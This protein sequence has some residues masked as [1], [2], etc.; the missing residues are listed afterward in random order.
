MNA[1]R[2]VGMIALLAVA[3]SPV[4]GRA[5]DPPPTRTIE[6]RTA[7][8]VAYAV[9]AQAGDTIAWKA[10]GGRH[11]VV[12]YAGPA[13]YTAFDSG[14]PNNAQ[15][16]GNPAGMT[17]YN[18]FTITYGGGV[19]KYRCTLA[20]S[21]GKAYSTVDG[22]GQCAGMCGTITDNPPADLP[23][24]PAISSPSA[25]SPE[26][27]N[28][29]FIIG[30]APPGASAVKVRELFRG[31]A[32]QELP[33]VE[34]VDGKWQNEWLFANGQHTIDAISIHQ[35]GFQSDPSATVTFKVSGPDAT[36]PTVALDRPRPVVAGLAVETS[37][38]KITGRASD[39]IMV[40][41]IEVVVVDQLT[42]ATYAPAV[43]CTKCGLE[44]DPAFSAEV[45][46]GSGYYNITVTATDTSDKTG[47]GTRDAFV[48]I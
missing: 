1:R 29:V 16:N 33:T 10:M 8:Y 36:P 19:V 9:A 44:K 32:V 13:G 14:S 48:V 31:G 43:V 11:N 3:L 5:A 47:S 17:P 35:D 12:S 38:L 18:T 34:V 42:Q 25:S 21:N 41:S 2:I 4:A 45:P 39:D 24:P 27:S 28:D 26:P 46:V 40:E 22:N 15:G 7:Q 23:G 37:P 20:D 6:I 30:T